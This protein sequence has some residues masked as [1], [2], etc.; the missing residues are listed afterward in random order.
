[1]KSIV[2][3]LL[4]LVASNFFFDEQLL[5]LNN[6]HVYIYIY[7]CMYRERDRERERESRI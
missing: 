3:Q 4:V 1:M 6:T 7:I 2:V 5:Q